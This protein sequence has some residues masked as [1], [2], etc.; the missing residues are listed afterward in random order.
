ME[1][2]E[3]KILLRP[4]KYSDKEILSKLANNKKIWSNLRDMFPHPYQIED[5]ERFIETI[6][7]Q[8][9]QVTFAIEFEHQF[10]GLIGITLQQDVYRKSAEIGYWL[11]EPIADFSAFTIHILLKRK[12][13][14]IGYWLGEPFWNKGIVTTALKLVT[15]YG[16]NELKLERLFAGVFEGNEGSKRALE[17]CGYKLEGIARKAVY[18]NNMLIDELRFGKL[19]RD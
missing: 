3:E 11:G 9:T 17:K 18:K 7:K 15:D 1:L 16:F 10:A 13:A 8:D 4:L 14:E 6:K 19:K 2:I 5:A 12:S